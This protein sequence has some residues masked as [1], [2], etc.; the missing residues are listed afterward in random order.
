MRQPLNYEGRKDLVIARQ[1]RRQ[2]RRLVVNIKHHANRQKQSE[3]KKNHKAAEDECLLAFTFVPACQQTL[4]QQLVRAVRSHRQKCSAQ[5]SRPESKR[6]S[7]IKFERGQLK[8]AGRLRLSCNGIPAAGNQMHEF[9]SSQQRTA[10]VNHQLNQVG[11]DDRGD[12][13]FE[14]INQRQHAYDDD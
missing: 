1:L 6:H 2:R 5:K 12:A 14:G 8:F 10:Y 4:H 9:I 11:P 7:K 13:A 3:L